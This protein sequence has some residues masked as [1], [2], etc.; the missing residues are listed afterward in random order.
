MLYPRF[1]NLQ[2]KR[3]QWIFDYDLL[4]I[5]HVIGHGIMAGNIAP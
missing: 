5:F 2:Q 1:P 4:E 3:C